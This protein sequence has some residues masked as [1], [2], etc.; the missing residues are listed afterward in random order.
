MGPRACDLWKGLMW[1]CTEPPLQIYTFPTVWM[2]FA[3]FIT[4]TWWI[5]G[6]ETEYV[7]MWNLFHVPKVIKYYFSVEHSLAMGSFLKC[8]ISLLCL[9]CWNFI[10]I[11][12]W[13]TV[14]DLSLHYQQVYLFRNSQSFKVV[15]SHCEDPPQEDLKSY[16]LLSR[17]STFFHLP[18]PNP[19]KGGYII[20]CVGI[21]SIPLEL[22]SCCRTNSWRVCL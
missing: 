1:P 14:F 8:R 10:S 2:P 4:D 11:C 19:A 3:F 12:M 7:V 17:P 13:Y 22:I 5:L 15:K 9:S 21:N 20:Y 18:I 6:E 16:V